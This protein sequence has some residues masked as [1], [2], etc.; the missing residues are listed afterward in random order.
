MQSWSDLLGFWIQKLEGN[1]KNSN[2]P[3]Q[4]LKYWKVDEKKKRKYNPSE[5]IKIGP[6]HGSKF[7]K[8]WISLDLGEIKPK[9]GQVPSRPISMKQIAL[10]S[11]YAIRS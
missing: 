3:I 8:Y 4:I 9:Y 5:K 1:K 7:K 2:I 6:F 11:P 10:D